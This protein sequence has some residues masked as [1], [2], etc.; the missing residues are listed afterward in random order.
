MS[1]I[2]PGY[3]TLCRSRCGTLNEVEGDRLVSVSPDTSHPTGK[4]MCMK[5]RAAP[6]IV[7]SPHRVFH[8]MRRT[9][10]KGARDPGWVRISWDEALTEIAGRLGT[11]KA[12]HGAEAVAFSVTTPSGTPLSDSIDWIERFVRHF[13]SPNICY[14]TEIC[15]WHKDVAHAFTFGCGIP[16]ADYE[17]ADTIMLWGHNPT[18]TWLAQADAIAR[19]RAKGAKLLVVDP[20]PTAL[21]RQ[22]DVW[23]PV[24][25]GTDGALALGL[26]RLLLETERFDESFV[27]AWTNA[28]FLVRADN[29][30]FLREQD[31]WPEAPH[32]R[33]LV[34]SLA[35]DAPQ[36]YEPEEAISPARARD[37]KIRGSVE[38]ETLGQ[39]GEASSLTCAP[40]LQHL[41]DACSGYDAARVHEITGVEP[42][43]LRAAA[44]L[45]QAGRRIAYHAWT[46]IG[47]HAN[48]TQTERAVATLYALTGSF[49]RVGANRVRR[50]PFFRP[51]NALEKVPAL[52]SKALGFAERPIGPPAMGWVT[53]RDTYR[54]I[55]EGQPYKVRAM[56]AFGTNLP[57]SQGDSARALEALEALDFHVHC[58]LF[59]TPAARY[60]DIFLPVN[61]PWEHEGLRFG[62][63]IS[64][65]AAS[66]VQFRP[67]MVPPRGESRSDCE[68]VFALA[69]RLGMGEAFFGGSLEAGW[70]HMLEPLNL[71]I[72][73]LRR[74]PGGIRCEIDS[75]EG[76]YALPHHDGE[77]HIRGFDTETRRVEIYSE[78]LLRHGQPAVASFT[79]PLGEGPLPHRYPLV[80]SSAKNGYYCHS[81]HRSLVSLRKR[82]P[83]PIAEI[84]PGLAASRGIGD[85]DWVRVST[86]VGDA[87]FKAR[88]TPQLS[89][90]VVV[91]EFGWWQACPELD[92]PELSIGDGIGS[93]FNSLISAEI[94]DPVSGSTPLRSFRCQIALDP[95]TEARQRSWKGWRTFHLDRVEDEAEGVRTFVFTPQDGQALPDFHPGQHVEIRVD[96]DGAPVSRT[97]SL[98]GPARLAGRNHY[99]ICVRHQKGRTTDG[100]PFEGRMS[101]HLH[102][103]MKAGDLVELRAPSGNFIVPRA[104]PQPLILLAGGI[105]ITPFSN[106]L[107]SLDDGDPLDITLLYANANSRSHAFRE[108]IAEHRRRLPG[109][110]VRNHYRRPLPEDRPGADYDSADDITADLVS[111]DLLGRHPRIYMC[112]SEA[113]MDAFA[114]GL[115]Q[116]GVPKFDIFREVFRSPAVVNMDDGTQYAVTFAASQRTPRLWTAEDGP[117]L[118]F[119]EKLGVS[120]PSGCRVGQCESCAVK[121]ISGKVVHLHGTEP[122]DPSICLTCQAA[123]IEDL[124]LDA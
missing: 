42:E 35:A 88:I 52:R 109:L 8:P 106:L 1:T 3:C 123:P 24:R 99:S 121:I 31:L 81:Q 60:A 46:G 16:P 23:L 66:R 48:A 89:D 32:N 67:R 13:G 64:D 90:D 14:G 69:E 28:P 37:F 20:R 29:G 102:R 40:A 87:R 101:G 117:L 58:D 116:R 82:A 12:E 118:G 22:A 80:L 86:H 72:A 73:R 56:M 105:G 62:F 100:D 33:A 77:P 112:G 2:V 76:K 75:R 39:D 68:I 78:L 91:A 114:N 85:G 65:E 94:A 79:Q 11:I 19:G 63:E 59:E 38:V 92:R 119:G 57:V 47:Q 96:I 27:R 107:E 51:V 110:K 54:A 84:G 44:E 7:H 74:E 34:W 17:N 71:S 83:D 113:M 93:N 98:T 49:D 111:D 95:L 124:V 97:Y 26:A 30:R 10:P 104:S 50:G 43:R 25:P 103:R 115:M 122:D 36:P 18:N 21:A 15:N 9:A 61:S 108:H 120:L 41:L 55:L 6:E 53:A 45:L 70:D 4:A 5:G